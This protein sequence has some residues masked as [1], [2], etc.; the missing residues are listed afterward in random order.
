MLATPG[1]LL[2]MPS[3]GLLD[4]DLMFRTVHHTFF[5]DIGTDG[6]FGSTTE[7]LPGQR[8]RQLQLEDPRVA[9]EYRKILHQQFIHHT[10]FRRIKEKFH[11]AG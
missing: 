8:F 9:K 7:S 5:I 2:F 1:I 11:S 4:F 6:F 3:I 10:V